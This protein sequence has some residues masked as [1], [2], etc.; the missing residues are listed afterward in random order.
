MIFSKSEGNVFEKIQYSY[1][2]HGLQVRENVSVTH[3]V[4]KPKT[5]SALHEIEYLLEYILRKNNFE[6][7]II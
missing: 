5:G 7:L 2:L 4:K 1:I 6:K 3:K